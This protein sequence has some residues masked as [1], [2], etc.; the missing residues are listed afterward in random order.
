MDLPLMP[1]HT[2][3]V[4]R[5]ALLIPFIAL[6]HVV[7][8]EF[9]AVLKGFPDSD[10]KFPPTHPLFPRAQMGLRCQYVGGVIHPSAVG[11]SA[12]VLLPSHCGIPWVIRG[13]TG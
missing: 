3:A 10:A 5:Q 4:P 9:Q 11:Y 7:T 13:R 1:R 6:S 2:D 12:I 8:R